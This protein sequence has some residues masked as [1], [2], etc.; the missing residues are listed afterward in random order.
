MKRRL[1]VLLCAI[2]A[3]AASVGCVEVKPR[4]DGAG[5]NA[6]PPR[7]LTVEERDRLRRENEQL[8]GELD[9]LRRENDELRRRKAGLKQQLDERD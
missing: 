8:A 1:A 3:A 6:P 4:N 9:R 7:A 5:G 2:P